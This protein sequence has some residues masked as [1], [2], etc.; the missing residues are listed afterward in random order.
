MNQLQKDTITSFH[1]RIN[2]FAEEDPQKL[3]HILSATSKE[4]IV[5]EDYTPKAL[6]KEVIS[7]FLEHP[8]K[9]DELMQGVKLPEDI[10]TKK[11]G[12]SALSRSFNGS[13]GGCDCES[14]T[15][16]PNSSCY[17]ECIGQGTQFGLCDDPSAKNYLDSGECKYGSGISV[18]GILDGVWNVAQQV[19][20]D[21]IFNWITGT[22]DDDKQQVN[23]NDNRPD[24]VVEEKKTDW[25]KIAIYGGI[26]IALGV[27]IYFLVKKKK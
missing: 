6:T 22:D 25:T 10:S 5:V 19:G 17:L 16:E 21:N 20:L 24:S 9:F 12:S 15:Y 4:D 26:V 2:A 11:I 8:E 14:Y 18:G 13:F 1:H 23:N 27:G 7:I 3:S